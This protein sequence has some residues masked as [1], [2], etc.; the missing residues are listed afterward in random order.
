MLKFSLVT[1]CAFFAVGAVWQASTP[2][3]AE[4]RSCQIDDGLYAFDIARISGRFAI[5]TL[6]TNMG[7]YWETIAVALADCDGDRSV[8]ATASPAKVHFDIAQELVLDSAQSNQSYSM[9]DIA[10][11]L[12]SEGFESQVV[13]FDATSCVCAEQNLTADE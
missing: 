3:F 5:Y 11:R 7:E 13:G 12:Q 10:K 8:I 4:T 2:A 9:G 1:V 6:D